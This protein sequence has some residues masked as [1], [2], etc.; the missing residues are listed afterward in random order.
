[1]KA[2]T[3]YKREKELGRKVWD[4]A[5]IQTRDL[6]NAGQMLLPLSHWTHGRGAETRIH[7]VALVNCEREGQLESAES[8]DQC[9][10][11]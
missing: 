8:S 1:M 6:P 3:G 11:M 7:I 4:P 2:D 5:G 9:C 10:Y